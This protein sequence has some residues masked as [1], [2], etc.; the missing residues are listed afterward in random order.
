VR[1]LFI[2]HRAEKTPECQSLRL[3]RQWLSPAQR[4][5][6]AES[7]YFEVVGCDT[8]I[9]A[10]L[11]ENLRARE[12]VLREDMEVAGHRAR[13]LKAKG[14]AAMKHIVLKSLLNIT[15]GMSASV[16]GFGCRPV[17]GRRRV[18]GGRRPKASKEGNRA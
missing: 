8:G 11:L 18:F 1:A 10:R 15:A 6:L 14:P 17:E 9:A 3:L 2:G 7:G 13:D 12:A 5:R 4:A 16:K